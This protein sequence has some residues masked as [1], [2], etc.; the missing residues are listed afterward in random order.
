MRIIGGHDYYDGGMA[1][2]RDDAVT[3]LRNE[4]RFLT[5]REMHERY[6]LPFAVSGFLLGGEESKGHRWY[7]RTRHRMVSTE[8][9]VEGRTIRRDVSHA[10]VILC[11]KLRRG[12]HVRTTEP[13]GLSREIEERWIWSADA[14]RAYAAEHSLPLDEGTD[15]IE[16]AWTSYALPSGNRRIDT[17]VM[18]LDS[19]FAPQDIEGDALGALIGDR[20]T[21]ASRNPL[22]HPCRN[23]VN[24]PLSWRINQASLSALGYAKAVDTYTAFQEIAMW[25]GGVLPSDGAR[26]VE[27]TD[28]RIK[29]AKHGFHHPTSFRKVKADA[30]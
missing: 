27:I 12:V 10:S 4:D 14:M 30:R 24:E 2:G 23:Q 18:S 11:G 22:E 6:G 13:Y 25:Q 9:R 3:F 26:M 17:A 29:I 20:I 1:W 28:D 8:T 21:I 16:Q 19:W 7:V 5:D 15:G